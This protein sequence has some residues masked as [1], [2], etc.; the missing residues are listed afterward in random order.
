MLKLWPNSPKKAELILLKTAAVNTVRPEMSEASCCLCSHSIVVHPV[1]VKI[2]RKKG[3]D[4]V[5]L[6]CLDCAIPS[7]QPVRQLE[8][9]K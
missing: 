1:G 2:I 8:M 7:D 9:A 4:Q 5:K 3:P 6:I